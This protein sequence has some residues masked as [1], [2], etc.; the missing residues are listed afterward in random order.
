MVA[1]STARRDTVALELRQRQGTCCLLVR[2]TLIAVSVPWKVV[3]SESPTRLRRFR[4]VPLPV[5]R[6]H[7]RAGALGDVDGCPWV[8]ESHAPSSFQGGTPP[9]VPLPY[10]RG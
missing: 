5:C 9:G 4:G 1:D 6:F 3:S 7:T 8:R 2:G 10:A